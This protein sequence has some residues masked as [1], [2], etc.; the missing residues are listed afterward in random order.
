[1]VNY[2]TLV[3]KFESTGGLMTFKG[4]CELM[5]VECDMVLSSN[6]EIERITREALKSQ[7]VDVDEDGFLVMNGVRMSVEEQ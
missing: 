2:P 5:A 3:N 7:D 6:E 4:M 1:M